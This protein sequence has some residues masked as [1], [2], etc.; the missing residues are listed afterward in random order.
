MLLGDTIILD[1]L[2]DA[3]AYRQE[4]VK[5]THCP[6]I[7]TRQGDRIRS[8]GKF[9]GLMNKA[10]PIEKLRGVVFAEPISPQYSSL[11]S[12]ID[13]LQSYKVAVVRRETSNVEL[14]EQ[15]QNQKTSEMTAKYKE[16]SEAETQLGQIEGRLGMTPTQAG[17]TASP[18]QL[19]P[20]EPPAKRSRTSLSPSVS[21]N[22]TTPTTSTPTRQS[23]RRMALN[24]SS[25]ERKRYRRT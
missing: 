2:S 12:M 25:S 22:G 6:T 24:A 20:V 18:A 10:L 1:T 7:L 14:G 11:C 4:I 8:N 19:P 16:C 23:L 5:N 3:N 21:V 13:L 15:L 9:G 17:H